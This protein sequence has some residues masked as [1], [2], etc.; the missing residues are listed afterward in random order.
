MVTNRIT[1]TSF[2]ADTLSP[3]VSLNGTIINNESHSGFRAVQLSGGMTNSFVYQT[4]PVSPGESF[5]LIVS[6][7]KVGDMPAPPMTLAINYYDNA[8]NFMDYGI[9]THVDVDRIPNVEN[10]LWHTR[11]VGNGS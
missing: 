9:I 5:E 10:C 1:N 4:V 3:W 6:L 11:N 8:F 7:A 2:E